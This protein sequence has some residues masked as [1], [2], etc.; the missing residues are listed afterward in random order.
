MLIGF[1][2]VYHY[3]SILTDCIWVYRIHYKFGLGS[4]NSLQAWAIGGG[5][6]VKSLEFSL[7][8]TKS[9]SARKCISWAYWVEG[10]YGQ[11]G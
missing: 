10:M 9:C 5:E 7:G 2:S 11:T 8:L 3:K 1:Y 6:R 4:N